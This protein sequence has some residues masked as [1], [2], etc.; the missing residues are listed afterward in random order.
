M[1]RCKADSLG[2]RSVA[3]SPPGGGSSLSQGD[4]LNGTWLEQ[5]LA[6]GERETERVAKEWPTV[7][8]GSKFLGSWEEEFAQAMS[9]VRFSWLVQYC[10]DCVHSGLV[11][12]ASDPFGV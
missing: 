3:V 1:V 11:C 5:T 9:T 10:V 8:M 7:E 6:L 4:P 2:T 12:A